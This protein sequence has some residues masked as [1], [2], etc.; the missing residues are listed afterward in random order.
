MMTMG[1]TILGNPIPND[2]VSIPKPVS[3]VLE[4]RT[5][6]PADTEVPASHAT[7][8]AVV[9]AVPAA[10]AAQAG[11]PDPKCSNR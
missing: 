1:M 3:M 2:P 8:S 7:T 11:T 5:A 4:E 6:T 10:L 9:E